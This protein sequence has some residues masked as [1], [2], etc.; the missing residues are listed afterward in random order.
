LQ[1][2]RIIL[3]EERRT[4]EQLEVCGEEIQEKKMG[5]SRTMNF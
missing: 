4:I 2:G 1:K 5:K 3:S